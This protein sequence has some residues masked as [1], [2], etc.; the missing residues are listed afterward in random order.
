M[1]LW[2]A[3]LIGLW[4]LVLFCLT[5]IV[6]LIRRTGELSA[7]IQSGRA[8]APVSRLRPGDPIPPFTAQTLSGEAVSDL[9]TAGRP[10]V[11]GFFSTTC[12]A[13]IT[14]VPAFEEVL[15][16]AD[17]QRLNAV[18]AFHGKRDDVAPLVSDR[19]LLVLV[20]QLEE[21]SILNAFGISVF[22]SYLLLSADGTIE[23]DRLSA[24]E[25]EEWIAS[26]ASSVT[27]GVT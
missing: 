24:R 9:D 25:V 15:R 22:P 11:V 16:S 20:D 2:Q 12:T 21:G 26:T 4:V 13:C 3:S 27:G 7:R 18:L 8:A 14:E 10:S 17:P 19:D 23:G 1:T 5:L 6:G